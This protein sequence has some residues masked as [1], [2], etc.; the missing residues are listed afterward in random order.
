MTTNSVLLALSLLAAPQADGALDAR[1][2]GVPLPDMPGLERSEPYVPPP[3]G[4]LVRDG[5]LADRFTAAG[6]STRYTFEARAGELSIFEL[7]TTGFA[8]GWLAAADLRVLDGQ[9]RVLATAHDG[10]EAQFRVL[11]PFLAEADGSYAL[12][13]EPTL[14][15]FRYQIVRHSSYGSPAARGALDVGARARVHTWLGPAPSAVRL[16]VPVRA[17]EELV[18]RVEGTRE[19]AR[20]ERRK[21]RELELGGGE[22][23]MG[24]GMGGPRMRMTPA[25]RGPTEPVF[26][27]ARLVTAAAP[28]LVQQGAT[29]TRLEPAA[30]GWLDLALLAEGDQPALVDL[31]VER[32]PERV[33]VSGA[34][35]D[36]DDEGL[37]GLELEFLREPDLDVWATTTS[38]ADGA[39]SARLPIG[40]WR[41]RVRR[42]DAPPTVLRVGVSGPTQDLVLL[43]P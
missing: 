41:V 19:E 16:R 17:G 25:E 21:Q 35:I 30:D 22:A 18:V 38:G 10:G 15:Y 28:G 9:G 26:A 34:L 36:A 11:L 43:L 6:Q 14:E 1:P 20:E 27:T 32:A 2:A 8:R 31:V 7:A 42:G 29:L 13:I 5:A 23:A 24:M 4:E 33:P 3:G 39:W 37:S 40:D 12:E